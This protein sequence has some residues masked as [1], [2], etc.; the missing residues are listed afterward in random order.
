MASFSFVQQTTRMLMR[1]LIDLQEQMTRCQSHGELQPRHAGYKIDG[2]N[3]ILGREVIIA[4]Q[5]ST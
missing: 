5:S 4:I 1:P 2:K 3:G